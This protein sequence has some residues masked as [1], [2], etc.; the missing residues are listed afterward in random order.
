MELQ[1]SE[2]GID[3]I[4][5]L[6]GS[7][8]RAVGLVASD[9]PGIMSQSPDAEMNRLAEQLHLLFPLYPEEVH[10][11]A[12]KDIQRVE[13]LDGKRVI[14]GVQ[15]TRTW[16]TAHHLLKKLGVQ[17]GELISA[18]SPL[19]AIVAVL[20]G[21]ADAMFYV[22]DKPALPFMRMRNLLGDAK[23]A[24]LLQDVNFVPL[25]PEQAGQEY[26]ASTLSP[27]DYTWIKTTVPTLAV[28]MVLASFD[29]A[30]EASDQDDRYCGQLVDLTRAVRDNFAAL[31][32]S[33]HAKWQ[34]VDLDNRL[35]A[36]KYHSCTQPETAR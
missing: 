12:R 20:R 23:Y 19:K 17:P 11:F 32:R 35:A 21:T 18:V 28:Q 26:T 24:S 13:D 9:M 10:L 15:G 16:L 25:N 22:G 27:Q 36:W 14:V 29:A 33:G 1:Q 31:Q 6:L 30:K 5:R 4:Q 2:G 8:N 34:E 7:E 3:T